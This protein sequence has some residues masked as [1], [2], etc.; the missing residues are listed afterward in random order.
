MDELRA[1]RFVVIVDDEDRENEGDLALA[2][3]LVSPEAINFMASQGRGLICCPLTAERLER[4]NIPLMV[5]KNTAAMGTAFC[6]SVDARHSESSGASAADRALTVRTLVDPASRPSDLVRP[7]HIFPIRASAGGVLK[8]AG[9][10]EAIVDL[11]RLAGLEPAG[12]ICEIMNEDGS[13]ARLSQLNRFKAHHGLKMISIAALIEYRLAHETIVHRVAETRLP[14]EW[15]EFQL[16]AFENDI[17]HTQHLAL[18]MGQPSAGRPALVRVQVECLTG[19][20]LGSQRCNC[21]ARLS[22]S[23]RAISRR[24][25]GVLVYLRLEGP[26]GRLLPKLEA[27]QTIDHGLPVPDPHQGWDPREYGAG[28]QILRALGLGKIEVLTSDARRLAGIGGYGL[29][30]VGHVLLGEDPVAAVRKSSRGA[31]SK[32]ASRAPGAPPPSPSGRQTRRRTAAAPSA[33]KPP[34]AGSALPRAAA[35]K[36]GRRASSTRRARRG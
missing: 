34:I 17:D 23:L 5:Q 31:A 32:R 28:A 3:E 6:V 10:T 20:A 7:G 24:G 8:R 21:R 14:T 1:G 29:D 4:L 25:E 15:G 22:Q 19:D 33:V 13:M 11:T 35:S 12:V 26:N 9:H 2:A 16:V 18:V 36:S 30:V 27:Y